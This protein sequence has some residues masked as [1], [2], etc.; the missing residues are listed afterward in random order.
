MGRV[1]VG[2]LLA[3]AGAFVTPPVRLTAPTRNLAAPM[4]A[5]AANA[6]REDVALR[7]A[8]AS[9]EDAAKPTFFETYTKVSSSLTN[10]FPVWT[11]VFTL[12]ALKDPSAFAWLTTRYFTA[13]LAVLMLSMG[14]TLAPSDF[15]RV[16]TRPNAVLLNFL[17]C[18]G[19]MPAL[20]LGLGKFFG[21]D[22][23]LVAGMVLVG[24]I[25]GGQASNL[26][27]FIANGNV[28]LSVLMTTATT[29]GAIFM[30]PLLCKTFLG[31]VVPVDAAGIV[32]STLQVVLAPI[33]LGMTL[34]AKAPGV[35][36]KI[37]PVT[38]VVGM[39]STCLLVA[40]AVGQVA[41]PILAA[42]LSL[43][44]PVMLLHLVGGVVGYWLSRALGF[45]ETTSRTM[46]I[47]T[48]MKSSAF[49]F[50][51]AKLHFGAFAARVPSAVS[52]VWMALTGS[53]MAVAWRFMPVKPVKF[54]RSVKER[55]EKVDLLSNL[56]K[57]FGKKKDE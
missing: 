16:A 13:G 37:I 48:S 6:P 17:L 27:T 40:A 29:I 2:C 42:G 12:W 33:V 3:L 7:A 15:V 54:D 35:V 18:Y 49:G 28:A 45:G 52:V 21:L 30:T 36:K 31:T 38:P 11:V 22:P 56:K 1:A 8:V 14:I 46:A 39:V 10:L 41:E 51:L 47:E 57:F 4:A 20:G 55:F 34:N 44:L 25:N 43:Q 19:M 24:S 5:V 23:A 50:L 53:S 32:I 9:T 26:C